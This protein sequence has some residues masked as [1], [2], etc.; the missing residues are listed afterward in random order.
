M[1]NSGGFPHANDSSPTAI[2]FFSRSIWSYRE[3]F[4]SGATGARLEVPV[5]GRETGITADSQRRAAEPATVGDHVSNQWRQ[6]AVPPHSK[7]QACA[8]RAELGNAEET[9]R[10]GRRKTSRR[11]RSVTAGFIR[12]LARSF[13]AQLAANAGSGFEQIGRI[14]PRD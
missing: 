12:P 10:I 14:A 6:S 5:G 3:K 4:T 13:A 9:G 1:T 7:S 8:E 2:P 11:P